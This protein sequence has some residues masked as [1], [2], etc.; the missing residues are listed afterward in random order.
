VSRLILVDNMI[1]YN[2][3]FCSADTL[4]I[5]KSIAWTSK[6]MLYAESEIVHLEYVLC[7]TESHSF[8][9]KMSEFPSAWSLIMEFQRYVLV[10]LQYD[11][12]LLGGLLCNTGTNIVQLCS[13]V[14]YS[15]INYL[16]TWF[17][18]PTRLLPPTNTALLRTPC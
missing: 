6:A 8:W 7:S 4:A 9:N 18:S 15:N 1:L 13:I 3:G 10:R 16:Q 11:C 17:G 5:V 12:L 2:V 14:K